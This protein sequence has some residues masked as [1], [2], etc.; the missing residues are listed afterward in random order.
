MSKRAKG[1]KNKD[2]DSDLEDNQATE[3]IGKSKSKND[4]EKVAK[5]GNKKGKKQVAGRYL[6]HN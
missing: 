5:K 2:F 3:V 4:E 1:K 6:L